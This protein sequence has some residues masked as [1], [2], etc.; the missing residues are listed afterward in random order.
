METQE[1]YQPYRAPSMAFNGFNPYYHCRLEYNPHDKS[2][3]IG[4]WM[5]GEYT[6]FSTGHKESNVA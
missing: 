2:T 6:A 3:A 4:R 5:Y 1:T